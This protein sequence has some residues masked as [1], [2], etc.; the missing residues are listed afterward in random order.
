MLN[1]TANRTC[2]AS[3]RRFIVARRNRVN[4]MSRISTFVSLLVLLAANSAQAELWTAAPTFT[5]SR[6]CWGG[7]GSLP[8]MKKNQ[9]SE[10]IA[11]AEQML[12][13]TKNKKTSNKTPLLRRV[14]IRVAPYGNI[15][16]DGETVGRNITQLSTRLFPGKHSITVE[17]PYGKTVKK[18]LTA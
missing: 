6:S 11:P 4:L 9:T 10:D 16:I 1:W 3:L 8:S 12:A 7:Q 18:E 5:S 15:I 14:E 17:N 2:K 13:T